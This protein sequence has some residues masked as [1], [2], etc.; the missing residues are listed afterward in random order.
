MKVLSFGEVL[1]DV[2]PQ[3][4][5]IGG[6]PFNFAAHIAKHGEEVYMLSAVGC[7]AL[8]EE[9]LEILGS[10]NIKTDYISVL[11]DKP[12]GSCVVTLDENSVPTYLLKDNVAYDEIFCDFVKNDFDVLYF[13]TLALRNEYNLQALNGLLK[14]NCYK[15]IFVDVNIREP[16]SKKNTLCFAAENA[17]I[18]KISLEEMNTVAK[19]LEV[20]GYD[21]YKNFA[22]LICEKYSNIKLVIITLGADGA[23]TYD[24][25]KNTEHFCNSVETKVVSTVGAGDSFLAAFLYKYMKKSD[26]DSCIEYA[27]RVAGFVV[28][29]YEAVPEYNVTDFM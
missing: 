22:R 18:I 28:S 27:S 24:H 26:L 10:L 2:Y 20:C 8:G 9:A 3:E 11:R 5:Y 17:T 13:G 6:A 14:Q 19:M 16:F 1:W 4:K 21:S 15:E 29:K 25:R 12:T 7:D 23:Y